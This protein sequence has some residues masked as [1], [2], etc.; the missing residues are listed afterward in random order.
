MPRPFMKLR[1]HLQKSA[2]GMAAMGVF[3]ALDHARGGLSTICDGYDRK[4]SLRR[5]SRQ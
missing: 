2:K 5:A 4:D 3:R 1:K